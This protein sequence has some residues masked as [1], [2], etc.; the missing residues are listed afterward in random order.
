[1]CVPPS[2]LISLG[3]IYPI[4]WTS[5]IFSALN[6]CPQA[7]CEGSK[8]QSSGTDE[9]RM[10]GGARSDHG[11]RPDRSSFAHKILATIKSVRAS[12][13]RRPLEATRIYCL[14]RVMT[15]SSGLRS[16][17]LFIGSM[18]AFAGSL[19]TVKL[20]TVCSRSIFCLCR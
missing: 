12:G 15:L 17:S 6:I 2:L 8:E 20:N 13:L 5:E 9:N 7:E 3:F 16:T 4:R 11:L 10:R 18:P 14:S 19:S 1:V